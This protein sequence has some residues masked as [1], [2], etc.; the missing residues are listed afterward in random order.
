[1]KQKRTNDTVVSYSYA[2]KTAANL[3]R[4]NRHQVVPDK[5]K[6][7]KKNACRRQNSHTAGDF[8]L[9]W[10]FISALKNQVCLPNLQKLF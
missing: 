8:L 2:S 1:M 3:F 7:Q 4:S 5:K 9:I 10:L 6:A